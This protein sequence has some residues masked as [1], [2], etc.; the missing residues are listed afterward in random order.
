MTQGKPIKR[1]RIMLTKEVTQDL[2]MLQLA[3]TVVGRENVISALESLFD[4]KY[5]MKNYPTD[6]EWFGKMRKEIY[7][8]IEE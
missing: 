4:G 3:E 8:L 5:T 1:I 6:P 2:Q 7:Q